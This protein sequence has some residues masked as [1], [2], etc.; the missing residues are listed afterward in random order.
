MKR[1]NNGLAE[2]ARALET[3]RCVLRRASLSLFCETLAA[4]QHIGSPIEY[5]CM[6]NVARS[7][8]A[9]SRWPLHV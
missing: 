3:I 1:F 6:G 4:P 9:A 5:H 7:A 8:Q 2:L